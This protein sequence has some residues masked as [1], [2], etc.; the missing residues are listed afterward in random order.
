[1]THDEFRRAIERHGIL[2]TDIAQICGVT[3]RTVGNWASGRKRVPKA[4]SLLL[5]ADVQLPGRT[6]L[7]EF[8]A[9]GE[10]LAGSEGARCC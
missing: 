5:T 3:P 1:M 9:P 4:L 10:A 8:V 2:Q 7:F 6:G